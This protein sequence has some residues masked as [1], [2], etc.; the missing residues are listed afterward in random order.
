MTAVE[1]RLTAVEQ[2]LSVLYERQSM[3]TIIKLLNELYLIDIRQLDT[4]ILSSYES[5]EMHL[6]FRFVASCIKNDYFHQWDS[7]KDWL[8]ISLRPKSIEYNLL[9]FGKQ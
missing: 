4:R 1:T 8:D 3:G 2:G 5:E 7:I 6:F 9:G